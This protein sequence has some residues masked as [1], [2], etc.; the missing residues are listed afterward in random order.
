MGNV[1]NTRLGVGGGNVVDFNE[2]R[3]V[4]GATRGNRIYA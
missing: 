3:I 2:C 4:K 1:A